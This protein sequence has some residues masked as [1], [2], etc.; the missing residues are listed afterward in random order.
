M[1]NNP[2]RD[3]PRKDTVRSDFNEPALEQPVVDPPATSNSTVWIILAAAVIVIL[4][5]GM[6]T[7]NRSPTP[8]STTDATQ[9]APGAVNPPALPPAAPAPVPSTAASPAP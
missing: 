1:T 4:A 3:Y 2:N 7:M 8:V 5:I 6:Y 9:R